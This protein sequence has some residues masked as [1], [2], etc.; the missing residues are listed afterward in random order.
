MSG[1][2]QFL[3]FVYFTFFLNTASTRATAQNS[4]RVRSLFLH[5]SPATGPM[6]PRL[7][8]VSI[9]ER[10][11]NETNPVKPPISP[12]SRPFALTNSTPTSPKS[13]RTH[14]RRVRRSRLIF[15]IEIKKRRR[16]LNQ[17]FHF[18]QLSSS[19]SSLKQPVHTPK[20][21]PQLRKI[22]PIPL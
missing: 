13:S 16:T 22:S 19:N 1:F 4:P 6:E 5:A 12:L 17:C 15:Y 18:I 11:A 9:S 3:H 20:Y 8:D 2:L 7:S 14:R 10:V 21:G